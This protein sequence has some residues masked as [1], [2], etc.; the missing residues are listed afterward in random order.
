MCSVLCMCVLCL[1][2]SPRRSAL[3]LPDPSVLD[4]VAARVPNRKTNRNAPSLSSRPALGP[5]G[6]SFVVIGPPLSVLFLL[7]S[8]A[9]RVH[10]PP[11]PLVESRPYLLLS[12]SLRFYLLPFFRSL[13]GLGHRS[14]T[15]DTTRTRQ[16]LK[17]ESKGPDESTSRGLVFETG[18]LGDSDEWTG[19]PKETR[20]LVS[21]LHYRFGPTPFTPCL[22]KPTP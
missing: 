6:R 20:D 10:V 19:A 17:S 16:R 3:C 11:H 21:S 9:T 1:C 4:P 2:P 12:G 18:S 15:G 5:V 14:L 7:W 8:P 13:P 22:S